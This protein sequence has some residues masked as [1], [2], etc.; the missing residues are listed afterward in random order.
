MD[1]MT[2]EARVKIAGLS[3]KPEDLAPL[4][5]LMMDLD[6]A[7]AVVRGH[8]PYS[9]EPLFALRLPQPTKG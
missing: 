8:R 1:D 7:A 2:F 9:D 6:R 3:P 4:R 5:A